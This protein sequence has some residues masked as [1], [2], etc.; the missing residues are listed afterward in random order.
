M[1]TN[2]EIG[3]ISYCVPLGKSDHV[4][5]KLEDMASEERKGNKR[6]TGMPRGD[7]KG[8]KKTQLNNSFRNIN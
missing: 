8:G 3:N 4:M 5:L 7:T 1:L 6:G 2:L